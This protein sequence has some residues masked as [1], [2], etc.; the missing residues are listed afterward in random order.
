MTTRVFSSDSSRTAV[1][2]VM[3]FSFTKSAMRS[4]SNARAAVDQ[5]IWELGG[6]N[7]GFRPALVVGGDEISRVLFHVLHQHG[8]ERRQTRFSIPHR[9]GR[10]AFDRAEIPLSVH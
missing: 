4:T 5:Q 3:I 8:P 6:K 9:R 2:S 1:M 10:I 7:C